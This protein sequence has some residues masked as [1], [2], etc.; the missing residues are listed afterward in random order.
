LFPSYYSFDPVPYCELLWQEI[1]ISSL[2]KQ[3]KKIGVSKVALKVGNVVSRPGD[4]A[5]LSNIIFHRGKAGNAS[6]KPNGL[7]STAARKKRI[8]MS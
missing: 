2:K 3:N 1:A 5:P 4:P 6:D 8:G 7:F